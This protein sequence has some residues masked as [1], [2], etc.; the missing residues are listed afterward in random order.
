MKKLLAPRSFRALSYIVRD[1]FLINYDEKCVHC[2]H[3]SECKKAHK[4]YPKLVKRYA[5]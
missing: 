2:H 4:D 5:S 3:F 1:C